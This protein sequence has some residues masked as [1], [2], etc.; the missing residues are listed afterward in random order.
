MKFKTKPDNEKFDQ[1]DNS[2]DAPQE[3]GKLKEQFTY[4]G[5]KYDFRHNIVL[6]RKEFRDSIHHKKNSTVSKS[7]WQILTDSDINTIRKH[8]MSEDLPLSEKDLLT[9]IDSKD[10]AVRY[11]PLLDYF[12]DL[13]E[14]GGGEDDINK[15][16]R[17]CKT[18]ND[19]LFSVVLKR[20]LV[21]SVECLLNE[22]A[23]NDI[24]LI[25]QGAQGIGKSRW[26]RKLLPNEFMREYY[27]EGPIDTS[28]NDHVE[29]LSKCWFINL[30]ELEVMNK[31]SV[32]SLKSFVT[33]Q[34]INFRRS[35]GKFS[36]DYL[37]RASF[38]GSVNDTTFLTDMTGNRRWLVFKAY[39]MDHMHDLNID[40]I[41]AQAY[42]LYLSGYRSWF[43]LEDIA[44]I[45][46]RNEQFRDQSYE[47][48]LIIRF[49]DFPKT[50]N[51]SGEWLSSSDVIDFL[52]AQNKSQAGKL[53]ARTVGRILTKNSLLKKRSSGMT[54]Y[55]LK[56][57]I[58]TSSFSNNENQN[59]DS[60]VFKTDIEEGDDL[61]F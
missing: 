44:K 51:L 57:L 31:N 47:E 8:L 43:N 1:F 5:A 14:W 2:F 24:C 49:F 15:L 19:E 50:E 16:A 60:P 37:R 58:D 52:S 20:F 61:P 48:E 38:I 30:E 34:R 33:R 46:E 56:T 6:S 45:N 27:Y 23:V 36:E 21:S 17:T 4:L 26:M 12:N 25:M 41:W 22:D 35:Y 53:F 54:K 55:Y 40:K 32:N 18:D 10:T 39:E 3:Q 28:K 11:N 13:E 7:E 59:N 42:S 29:Y 9:Y